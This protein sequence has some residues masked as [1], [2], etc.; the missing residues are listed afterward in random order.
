[1]LLRHFY[2]LNRLCLCMN[3]SYTKGS[4]SVAYDIKRILGSAILMVSELQNTLNNFIKT[5]THIV[6]VKKTYFVSNHMRLHVW[7]HIFTWWYTRAHDGDITIQILKIPSHDFRSYENSSCMQ[8]LRVA[9]ITQRL[10]PLLLQ[11]ATTL[12]HKL[13]THLDNIYVYRYYSHTISSTPWLLLFFHL[14][15]HSPQGC[16][17][18]TGGCHI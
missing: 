16:E 15:I 11:Y 3:S 5:N 1:M 18:Y 6:K 7:K 8:R 13:C 12:Q 10:N 4:A 2:T 14:I 17:Y 9:Y